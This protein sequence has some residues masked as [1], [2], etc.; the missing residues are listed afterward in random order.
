MRSDSGGGQVNNEKSYQPSEFPNLVFLRRY[1]KVNITT[2]TSP[3][4]TP[5]PV[6]LY[7]LEMSTGCAYLNNSSSKPQNNTV[8]RH[9]LFQYLWYIVRSVT[10]KHQCCS[11]DIPLSQDNTFSSSSQGRRYFLARQHIFPFVL[12]RNQY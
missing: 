8:P 5:N 7:P 4:L 12:F 9:L 3:P 10:H 1:R 6:S 11:N 2:E